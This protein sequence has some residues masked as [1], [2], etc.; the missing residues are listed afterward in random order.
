MMSIPKFYF[1]LI[2][3][4]GS[5][6]T[7]QKES[8]MTIINSSE[9]KEIIQQQIDSF[10]LGEKEKMTPEILADCY[11]ELANKWYFEQWWDSGKD[12]DIENAISYTQKA[13]KVKRGIKDLENASLNKSYFNL[14]VFYSYKGEIYAAIDAY[15]SITENGTDIELLQDTR[16]ELGYLYLVTGDF[17]KALDQFS[18]IIAFKGT[19]DTYDN[20]LKNIIDAQ[21]LIAETY[22]EMGLK[23]YSDAIRL[24]LAKADS[25][26]TLYKETHAQFKRRIDQL[27][28]NRLLETGEYRLAIAKHQK[29]LNDSTDLS[30]GDIASIYNSL[31][32]SQ[33]QLKNFSEALKNLDMAISVDSTYSL[34]YENLG[35]LYL[36]QK[37]FKKALLKYQKAI[38]LATDRTKAVKLQDL[39]EIQDLELASQKLFLLN[40]IVTKANGWFEFYEYDNNKD[41]LV[42]ALNTFALADQLVDIIRSESTEYRSKLF[43]REKGASLYAKAVETCYLLGKPDEAYYFMERNKALLLLEDISNEQAKEIA[44]LPEAM[45]EREFELRQAILF[46][47][48]DLKNSGLT[49]SDSLAFIKK[50]VYDQKR[51]Y[52]TF[53]DS[54]I[55]AF[56]EYA[57]LKKKMALLPYP[58]FKKKYISEDQTVLQYILN[59]EQGYGLITTKNEDFFFKLDNVPTLNEKLIQLYARLTDLVSDRKKVATYNRLSHELFKELLPKSAYQKMKGR[60]LII[61][62]DYILQQIPFE[63]FVT[64]TLSGSYLIENIE[65]RYAYSMSYL[66]AKKNDVTPPKAELF[67]MAPV[68]F[69]KL[70]LPE[71]PF[72]DTEVNEIEAIFP[73]ESALNSEATKSRFLTSLDSS[74]ILHLS[75]HA[76]ISEQ[77]DPWIAFNDEKMFLNEIYATKNQAEM[78]VLSACNTSIGE[79][80]KGEGAMSLARGFFHSGAKSVVSSLWSTNDKSSKEL[81]VAFYKGLNEGLTKSAALR[82]AKIEYIDQYRGSTISPAYWSALIVIG[83]N[84]P[85]SA[86][87]SLWLPWLWTLL[88]ILILLLLYFFVRSKKATS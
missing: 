33:L 41:H 35:D 81:M 74:K 21:I 77:T 39:P 84:S 42:H 60:K 15:S 62:P 34:P 26:I 22:A 88:G 80:R 5:I 40:H 54:L 51:T 64:D 27:E 55:G 66:E 52:D 29:V 12:D 72:S 68:Q 65:V 28:G 2:F 76:D 36:A 49:S 38:V 7:A 30:A 3:M 37:K 50:Q 67:G 20:Y 78:V 47:E 85:I 53:V 23:E 43:W 4:I 25:L 24:N 1:L 44:K 56:P 8:L 45:V 14:G 70:G 71:L 9:S 11:H 86:T 63:A 57:R 13:L 58:D 16:L 17:Y 82:K 48:N 69:V 32:Y 59:E 46:S 10:F 19:S 6:C 61:I 18:E 83:D 75:T 73:G 31:G 79:L 87:V